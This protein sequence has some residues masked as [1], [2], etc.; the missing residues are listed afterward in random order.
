M[1]VQVSKSLNQDCEQIPCHLSVQYLR[2][3]VYQWTTSTQPLIFN[4]GLCLNW[5]SL[6]NYRTCPGAGSQGEYRQVDILSNPKVRDRSPPPVKA[7][8]GPKD[9]RFSPP[10]FL[11]LTSPR[12]SQE[13]LG[14]CG[15][16][17]V[18]PGPLIPYMLSNQ[19][20]VRLPGSSQ[21][22]KAPIEN[23]RLGILK[24]T[25]V[26]LVLKWRLYYR[27]LGGILRYTVII[28]FVSKRVRGVQPHAE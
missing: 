17:P 24:Y 13:A 5:V 14:V 8:T 20:R 10:S 15:I 12:I 9:N 28:S 11:T 23:L 18:S 3:S 19:S 21:Y 22:Q 25:P 1:L 4:C 27:E 7:L 2:C 26:E 16:N 6:R